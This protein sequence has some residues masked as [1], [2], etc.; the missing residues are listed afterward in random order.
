MS[1]KF[2]RAGT[3][4]TQGPAA[5]TVTDLRATAP[6]WACPECWRHGRAIL[7]QA[8]CPICAART[9]KVTLR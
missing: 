2:Q 5:A 3:A 8:A 1:G 4:N 6:D 9:Y 7:K